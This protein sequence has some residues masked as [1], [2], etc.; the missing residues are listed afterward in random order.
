M[1]GGRE[2]REGEREGGGK[3]KQKKKKGEEGERGTQRPILYLFL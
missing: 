1:P 3:M 2:E